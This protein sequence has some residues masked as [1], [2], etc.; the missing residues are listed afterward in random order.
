MTD[1]EYIVKQY[2]RALKRIQ[3]DTSRL[4]H[5]YP[6]R[7]ADSLQR[8]EKWEPPYANLGYRTASIDD[9]KTHSISDLIGIKREA[10]EE[11]QYHSFT[12][13]GHFLGPPL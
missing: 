12:F 9:I 6:L 13:S 11:P 3:R 7:I 4:P 8:W 5:A 1:E 10:E 2:K